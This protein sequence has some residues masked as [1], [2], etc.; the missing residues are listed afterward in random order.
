MLSPGSDRRRALLDANYRHVQRIYAQALG[1]AQP[2]DLPIIMAVLDMDDDVARHAAEKLSEMSGV[3]DQVH[4]T[5]LLSEGPITAA[6]AALPWDLASATVGK[7]TTSAPKA[8]DAFASPPPQ[9]LGRVPV[10][11]IAAGGNYYGFIPT[12]TDTT[13]VE[14]RR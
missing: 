9:H 11:V 14:D 10:V 13:T 6:V 1:L 3:R 7:M 2:E 8:M 5:V 12:G 4:A